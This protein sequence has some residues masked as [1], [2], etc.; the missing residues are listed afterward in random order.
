MS[1][2][3]QL[4][5]EA[6]T[7]PEKARAL[8]IVDNETYVMAGNML[9]EIKGL[10]K[11]INDTFDPIVKKAYEAHKEAKAQKTKVEAPL[12]EAEGIIKPA[13]SAW[14]MEQERI[15]RQAELAA[16]EAARKAEEER[17][18]KEAESLEKQGDQKGVEEV[19]SA[20]I[21]VAPVIVQKTVPKVQG[22]SFTERWKFQIVDASKI[23]REY[24][25]PDEIK[26]GQVVRA[27]KG[28]TSIPGV[29]AYS[30]SGVSGR[31]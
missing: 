21:E 13:L 14:N 27:L 22:I 1:D 6:L 3:K 30:E 17:R 31:A 10:R 20:P 15:R 11:Q 16:Q 23:P 8:K 18:L 2:I 4:E 19:L 9:V 29:K 5:T 24:L 12:A 26:I 7:V 25:V 28:A